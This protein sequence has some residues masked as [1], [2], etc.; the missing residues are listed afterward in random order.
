M[1]ADDPQISKQM[2]EKIPVDV[3]VHRYPDP[4]H[5]DPSDADMTLATLNICGCSIYFSLCIIPHV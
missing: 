2:S 4:W 1:D 3:A 5:P